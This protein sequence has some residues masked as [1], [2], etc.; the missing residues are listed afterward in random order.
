[1]YD[2]VPECLI[3]DALTHS[4]VW[5]FSVHDNCGASTR[6]LLTNLILFSRKIAQYITIAFEN[7]NI[8]KCAKIKELKIVLDSQFICSIIHT[9]NNMLD[10]PDV[11]STLDNCHIVLYAK[12]IEGGSFESWCF[13]DFME[14]EHL[15]TYNF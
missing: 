10:I 2:S 6:I 14:V 12:K 4:S 13:H 3:A 1:M 7:Q 5:T 8:K 15:T 11:G 9:A